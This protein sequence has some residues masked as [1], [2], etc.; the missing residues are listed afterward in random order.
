[1][2]KKPAWKALVA[3]IVRCEDTMWRR[4]KRTWLPNA[5]LPAP[6]IG[7]AFG[8]GKPRPFRLALFA[9]LFPESLLHG[10]GKYRLSLKHA[11]LPPRNAIRV[12]P[13]AKVTI[14]IKMRA[15]E[16]HGWTLLP[17]EP[18][19]LERDQAMQ[20][21]LWRSGFRITVERCWCVFP[22]RV[23]AAPE[24]VSLRKSSEIEH[25]ANR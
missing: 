4:G 12:Q 18:V 10:H 1:M 25:P 2:A 5:A 24:S 6:A 15:E 7:F 23:P 3:R 11:S 8:R 19:D 16:T 21:K 17:H 14:R 13:K 22:G 20:P 9:L